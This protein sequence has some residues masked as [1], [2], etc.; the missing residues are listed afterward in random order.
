M[1]NRVGASLSFRVEARV[2]IAPSLANTEG[3]GAQR[4]ITVFGFNVQPSE[5]AKLGAIITL[6]S[7]L[8]DRDAPTLFG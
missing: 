5:F 6:A 7:T 3:L 8:K 1:P 2:I 4:W